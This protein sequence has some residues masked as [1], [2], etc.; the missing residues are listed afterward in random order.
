MLG[1]DVFLSLHC[2]PDRVI[3][4]FA[5]GSVAARTRSASVGI[6]ALRSG[7]DEILRASDED[8]AVRLSLGV[9]VRVFRRT[10]DDTTGE[11][12]CARDSR[13]LSM[14]RRRSSFRA[15][16]SGLPGG[17]GE[18]VGTISISSTN[19]S[20]GRVGEGADTTDITL[21]ERST[22]RPELSTARISLR[23][24][25]S[26]MERGAASRMGGRGLCSVML[27]RMLSIASS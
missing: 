27:V 24:G 10:G 16:A 18:D 25:I 12:V 6:R 15:R 11:C 14:E 21:S 17:G 23:L 20:H 2:L 5:I 7:S 1:S 13:E 22:K 9:L 8:C 4:V 19:I 3:L 26:N